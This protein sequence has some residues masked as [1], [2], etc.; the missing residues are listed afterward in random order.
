MP[1]NISRLSRADEEIRDIV[2]ALLQAGTDVTIDVNDSGDAVTINAPKRS[3]ES[4]RDLVGNTLV[5]GTDV[6]LNIDDAG[7][8]VTINATTTGA[9]SDPNGDGTYTLPNDTDGI[10]V[11]SLST[12]DEL[13]GPTASEGDIVTVPDNPT[14]VPVFFD[15]S[16]GEPLVPDLEDPQ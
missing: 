7:D 16:T 10:E 6:S 3:D 14:V 12:A 15:A 4:I 11:G 5:G 9:F 1:T 13:N 2:A 8:T